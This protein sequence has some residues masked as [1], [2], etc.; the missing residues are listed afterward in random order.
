MRALLIALFLLVPF[1]VLAGDFRGAHSPRPYNNRIN[2]YLHDGDSRTSYGSGLSGLRVRTSMPIMR[3]G[4]ISGPLKNPDADARKP[5]NLTA[6]IYT[7]KGTLLYERE[8]RVC[9]YKYVDQSK[10]RVEKRRQAWLK[11]QAEGAK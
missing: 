1:E 9:P 5:E 2:L 6:C 7:A 10:S 4:S 8:G 3:N 11:A